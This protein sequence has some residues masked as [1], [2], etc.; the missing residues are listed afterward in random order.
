MSREKLERDTIVSIGRKIIELRTAQG[1]SQKRLAKEAGIH[2]TGLNRI[3][4]G[5]SSPKIDSLCKIFDALGVSLEEALG[6]RRPA[7]FGEE[8]LHHLYS[9]MKTESVDLLVEV[10]SD[11]EGRSY[12]LQQARFWLSQRKQK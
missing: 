10:L 4:L 3:E 6:E 7:A 8:R 12:L 1:W 2:V 9:R 11:R 5:K